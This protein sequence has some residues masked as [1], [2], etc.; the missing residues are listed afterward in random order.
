MGHQFVLTQGSYMMIDD[1]TLK[2]LLRIDDEL[3]QPGK[4]LKR[5]GGGCVSPHFR[6]R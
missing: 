2:Q 5:R 4:W 3:M 1:D 6:R